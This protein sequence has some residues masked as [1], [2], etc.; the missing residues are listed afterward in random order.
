MASTSRVYD[1]SKY[2]KEVTLDP[3]PPNEM[4]IP[5]ARRNAA[6]ME[7]SRKS[8]IPNHPLNALNPIHYLKPYNQ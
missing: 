1:F 8:Y 7:S 2:E 6:R 4:Q 5:V 3:G